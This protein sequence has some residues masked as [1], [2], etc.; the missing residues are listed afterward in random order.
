[1]NRTDGQT[2]ERTIARTKRN[3]TDRTK[4]FPPGRPPK[5][6]LETIATGGSKLLGEHLRG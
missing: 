3:E 2:D 1:M 5:S 6:K 4:T